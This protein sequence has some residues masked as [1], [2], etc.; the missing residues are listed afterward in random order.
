M[1]SEHA[2]AQVRIETEAGDMV[3]EFFP[4]KAP[5]HV[6]NFI[7][8]VREGFYDGTR[9]HRTIPGFM[10]Q[11]GCPNTKDGAGGSP[12]TGNP[13]HTVDAEFNDVQHVRGI[14]SMARSQDV[15]SAGSQFFI[16]HGTASF[17]DGQYT[18]FGRLLEGEETL[19]SIVAAPCKSGGEGSSPV[20]PVK[21]V[22]M[23]VIDPE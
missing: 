17:L 7:K 11:G 14:F 8:L 4:D 18:A 21:I 3:A 20:E 10:I 23:T 12:G 9:F 15:N 13:G 1:S 19:D 16:C 22:K 5:R 2:G 6:D